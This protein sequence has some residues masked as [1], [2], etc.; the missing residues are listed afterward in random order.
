MGV[1]PLFTVGLNF[2]S[3]R[4]RLTLKEF[5]PSFL[6]HWRRSGS[7]PPNPRETFEK[8]SSKLLTKDQKTKNAY[9]FFRKGV[10]GTR[11]L[12]GA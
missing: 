6:R 4:F 1:S 12:V 11:P 5:H 10:K 7:I 8:V 9:A 2:A 3:A